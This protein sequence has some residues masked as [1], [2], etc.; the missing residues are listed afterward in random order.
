MQKYLYWPYD[1]LTIDFN[2]QDENLSLKTP[3]L[4]LMIK[5]NSEQNPLWEILTDKINNHK[6]TAHDISA[7]SNF[8]SNFKDYPISYILPSPKKSPLDKHLVSDGRHLEGSFTEQLELILKS[9]QK[10]DSTL[11]TSEEIRQLKN[12]LARQNWQWDNEA[13]LQF[14]SINDRIH[15]ESLFSV[16]RRYHYL[17]ILENEHGGEYL[18]R[19]NTLER[20]KIQNALAIIIRQNHFVTEQCQSSLKPALKTALSSIDLVKDFMKEEKGHDKILNKALFHLD[21]S[22]ET[23]D[24]SLQTRASMALLKYVAG[25]N[26]LAFSMAI[27]SFE[28]EP[29]IKDN[30]LIKSLKT[31]GFMESAKFMERHSTINEQGGHSTIA[32][33]FIAPM[34]LCSKDYAL[35]ALRLM[36][37]IS[38]LHCS[39]SKVLINP[40]AS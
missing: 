39:V 33:D 5:K 18:S 12:L 15:P 2:P 9:C 30:S 21:V 3:W 26:F 40:L 19:L 14:A 25:R 20:A 8:F 36:E 28:R 4:S 34:D 16:A 27:N 31:H 29:P 32:L 23:I 37:I 24:V 17:E 11:F 13:A 6:L 38:L 35:E 7:I 10:E 1:E 22:P